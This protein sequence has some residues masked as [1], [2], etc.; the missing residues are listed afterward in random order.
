MKEFASLPFLILAFFCFVRFFQLHGRIVSEMLPP[1]PAPWVSTSHFGLFLT[2]PFIA[3][4]EHQKYFSK[5]R[6]RDQAKRYLSL[7]LA[8]LMLGLVLAPP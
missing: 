2:M 3:W 4:K 7:G 6:D 1:P 8:F 5:S